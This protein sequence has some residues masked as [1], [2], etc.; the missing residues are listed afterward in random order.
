MDGDDWLANLSKLDRSHMYEEILQ[1][2]SMIKRAIE[3]STEIRVPSVE[4][5]GNVVFC[6]MGGSGIGPELVRSWLADEVT[7]PVDVVRD[8]RLPGYVSPSTLVCVVSY[9][10]DTEE[11]VSCLKEA[12]RRGTRPFSISSDGEIERL[13]VE[14]GVSHVRIPAGLAS[15]SSLPYLFVPLVKLLQVNGVV[16]PDRMIELQESVA[17]IEPVLDSVKVEVPTDRNESKSLAARLFGKYPLIYGHGILSGV[18]LRFKQQLNE[19]AKMP[20]FNNAFPELDHNELEAKRFV[21]EEKLAIVLLRSRFESDI[22]RSKIDASKQ[23]LES[24]GRVVFELRAAAQTAI[25]EALS[26]IAKLD[27]T[28]LYLALLNGV[29]PTSTPSINALK[30]M[31]GSRH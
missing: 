18:A 14:S 3:L 22:L 24:N 8:Y 26:F 7:V 10:G 17:S 21:V 9:S 30:E 23:I 28:S 12:I 11:E 25:A 1:F 19:I 15:R 27:M 5:I 13:S 29:D 16:S 2:P 31:L 20:A 4:G 6:G